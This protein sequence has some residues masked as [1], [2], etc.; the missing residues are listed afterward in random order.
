MDNNQEKNDEGLPPQI[1]VITAEKQP[2]ET[3]QLP[4]ND[5][6]PIV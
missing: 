6:M 5:P 2:E 4:V 1:P 3:E